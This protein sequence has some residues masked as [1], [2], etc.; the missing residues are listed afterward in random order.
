MTEFDELTERI[1]I[2]FGFKLEEVL[3]DAAI[4]DDEGDRR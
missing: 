3:E 4:E 1:S 2:A